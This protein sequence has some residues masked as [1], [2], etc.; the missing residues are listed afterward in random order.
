MSDKDFSELKEI[1]R[2]SDELGKKVLAKLEN[3]DM[4]KYVRHL[5]SCVFNQSP[6]MKM[7][8]KKECKKVG[9]IYRCTCGLDDLL[10]DKQ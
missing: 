2:K 4:I 5:D 7:L 3:G 6:V 10:K 1:I 9:K 8:L